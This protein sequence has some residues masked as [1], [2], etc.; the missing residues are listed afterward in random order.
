MGR[1]K[2]PRCDNCG[3]PVEFGSGVLEARCEYCGEVLIREL[4]QPAL[5]PPPAPVPW[6]PPPH[7]APRAATSARAWPYV[8]AGI[9][10]LTTAGAS[11]L[12]SLAARMQPL[13]TPVPEAKVSLAT[14]PEV[15][16]SQD[17]V[18]VKR[19]EARG[20]TAERARGVDAGA[21]RSKR[22]ATPT[23]PAA[24]ATP[25]TPVTPVPTAEPKLPRF[26]SQAAI[27]GLDAAK[28]KAEATCKSATGARLFVNMGFDPDG[29]NRGAAIS[30]PKLRGTPEAK[31]VLRVFRSVR[32]PPFDL[33]TRP[34]GL[35]R[36]VRF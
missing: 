33:A 25:V 23:A 32:I 3:A 18:S 30:D 2:V 29:V 27:S 35:G 16:V 10:T 24:A 4:P 21:S 11:G 20:E 34:G 12:A 14:V 8:I 28:A 17:S 7:T 36:L 9:A 26:D 13:P 19:A 22:S 31:C 15:R 6:H 5:A 1:V